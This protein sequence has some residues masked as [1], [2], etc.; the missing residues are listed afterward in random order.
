MQY[1]FPQALATIDALRAANGTERY[2]YSTKAWLLAEVLKYGNAS[3]VKAV[4]AAEARGDI[5]W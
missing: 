4:S 5:T 2:I 1:H 3:L